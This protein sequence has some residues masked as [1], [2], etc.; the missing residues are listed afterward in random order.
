MLDDLE[1]GI[2]NNAY[3]FLEKLESISNVKEESNFQYVKLQD[4]WKKILAE[5]GTP[6]R[7]LESYN[8]SIIPV[9][10]KEDLIKSNEQNELSITVPGILKLAKVKKKPLE[11][12]S[13]FSSEN[14]EV[15][16]KKVSDFFISRGLQP[17]QNMIYNQFKDKYGPKT[18]KQIIYYIQKMNET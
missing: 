1:D 18:I 14:L 17:D 4:I 8:N 15:E 10:K 2:K 5:R 7:T 16:S 13:L 3:D 11:N 9:L 12:Y 6:P